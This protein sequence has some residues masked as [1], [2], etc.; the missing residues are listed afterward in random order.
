MIV[1][2]V[3]LLEFIFYLCAVPLHI[4]VYF[5]AGQDLKA[6]AAFAPFEKRYA[7]RRAAVRL[8]KQNKPRKSGAPKN[9][10]LLLR[11]VLRLRRGRIRIYGRLSTGDAAGTS[12]L[13]GGIQAAECSLKPFIPDMRLRI[14]PD[15]NA[16]RSYAELEGM[17]TLRSGQI[18]LAAVSGAVK[19]TGRR[20][21][22]WISIRS[23]AS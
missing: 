3:A 11:M 4:A 5:R 10:R 13:I 1:Y 21:T 6:A 2:W 15:F 14:T 18:I 23:K 8:T 9:V 12:L 17:I 22:Q 7:Q 19:N 16:S 20:I